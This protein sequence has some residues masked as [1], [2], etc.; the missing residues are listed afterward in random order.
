MEFDGL[1]L[2]PD[3]CRQRVIK[4]QISG[5]LAFR[6]PKAYYPSQPLPRNNV[7][8]NM[9]INSPPGIDMYIDR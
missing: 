8:K 4:L 2:H 1:G 3:S 5:A 9:K 6:N 7:N